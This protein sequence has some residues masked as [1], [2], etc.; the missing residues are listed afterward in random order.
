[1]TQF[2]FTPPAEELIEVTSVPVLVAMIVDW[3]QKTL[4]LLSH[5]KDMPAGT[6]VTHEDNNVLFLEGDA[7]AGFQLGISLAIEE[8]STLPFEEIPEGIPTESQ[9]IVDTSKQLETTEAGA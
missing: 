8:L 7:L 9:E 1:M 3:Q 5:L 4:G 2:N 6:E